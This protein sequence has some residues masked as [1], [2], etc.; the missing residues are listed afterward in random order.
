MRIEREFRCISNL[1]MTACSD[2]GS[3]MSRK[4]YEYRASLTCHSGRAVCSDLPICMAWCCPSLDCDALLGLPDAPLDDADAR[5]R[6]RSRLS[7]RLCRRSDRQAL[8]RYPADR[9]DE[10]RCRRGLDIDPEVLDG[11]I[12]GAEGEST[13]KIL[14]PQRLLRDEFSRLGLSSERAPRQG[15]RFRPPLP[16][17]APKLSGQKVSL[18]SF[19]LG[20]QEYALPLDRVREIIQLPEQISEVPA[21]G[22][23][24]AWGR[25]AARPAA[26]AGVV[27]RCYWDYRPTAAATSLARSWCFRWETE[28]VG[29]VADRTR[30]IL[31]VDP[32][33]IDPAPALLTRGEG[34]AE[35]TQFAVSITAS[36]WSPALAR[37]SVPVR[38][39]APVVVR[40]DGSENVAITRIKPMEPPW[41]T[42]SSSFS[43]LA[44]RNTDCPSRRWTRSRGR[45]EQIAPLAQGTG[46]RRWR[47]ES[48]RHCCAN[49]RSPPQVRD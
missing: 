42:S 43:D 34:D 5:H 16:R 21:I 20:K 46:L 49:R 26:T 35:I 14:N 38:S 33:V 45:P 9:I 29:V 31:R 4:S 6:D 13:I 12:K 19:D 25:D 3:K 10:G 2:F 48:S 7:G 23:R 8:S 22:N 1:L 47:D 44:I 39:R 32:D 18:V 28:A 11:I 30:E 36:A 24:R 17:L 40:T 27:A 41:L 15:F 37:S